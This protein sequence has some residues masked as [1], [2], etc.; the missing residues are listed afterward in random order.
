MGEVLFRKAS[1]DREI[2]FTAKLKKKKVIDPVIDLIIMIFQYESSNLV[3]LT[4][5]LKA[6][7]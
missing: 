2:S 4:L 1:F 6:I 7:A 5:L 3:K